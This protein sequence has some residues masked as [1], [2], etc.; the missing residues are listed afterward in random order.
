MELL[1]IWMA[2]IGGALSFLS[3]CILPLAPGYLGIISGLSLTNLQSGEFSKRKVLMGTLAFVLGF[4]IVFMT[5]GLGSSFLGELLRANRN[6]LAR[7]SGLVV[8]VLG[9]HQAG[10]LKIPF[11]YRERRLVNKNSTSSGPLGAFLAGLA[12]ALGWTPCIGP[13][14]GSILAL[15]GNQGEPG[16]AVL[17]LG[18]YSLGLGVP[19]FLLALGFQKIS[20]GLNRI[21]PYLKYLQWASGLLLIMMGILLLTGELSA[22]SSWLI[23]ITGGWNP[24]S[25]L[26]PID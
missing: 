25:I 24:E 1:M 21:K 3:P 6:W 20:A 10:W 4:T 9:L 23:R 13:V 17:L 14:L 5:L 26:R 7:L 19:F 8:I 11:L 22:L 18:I 15:A 2:F 16:K 12:F